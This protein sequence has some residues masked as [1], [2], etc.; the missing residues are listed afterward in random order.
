MSFKNIST[1]FYIL[2]LLSVTYG[3]TEQTPQQSSNNKIKA[4]DYKVN[5]INSNVEGYILRDANSGFVNTSLPD[6]SIL[7]GHEGLDP[8]HV[9]GAR[10]YD[11]F[12]IELG[13]T[14]AGPNP[15]ITSLA[16]PTDPAMPAANAEDSW[17]CSH[18]HGFDYEGGVYEFNNGAT[19]NLLE[20]KDVRGRDEEFVIHMLMN[21]FD[22]WDGAGVV[23]V[24]NYTGLLTP[25]AMVDVADF[26]VN[27]IFDTH[28]YV[29]APTSG[30][31]NPDSHM[32]GMAFYNS[33][34]TGAIPPVIRVDGSNFNCVDCH[35][36]DGLL[37]PGIDLFT[38][39]WTNPF[40]W[41]H[42]VNFGSPRSLATFPDFTLDQTVH[43]GLYEVVLTD[44]LHF[45]GPEQASALLAHAEKN[46]TP[47]P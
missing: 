35:G 26:V 4:V 42:R 29:Q 46:L 41:L 15:L 40:Q 8:S 30:S 3:C 14:I 11:N 7:A 18:C 20:L 34:A 23:N 22:A 1:A 37:V 2:I 33:V 10:I 27:E 12:V 19:N 39:A 13:A 45:G 21:G 28:M 24:H 47:A 5:Q 32:D 31:T 17:R 38:L 25:Q 6:N 36:A 16:A 9:R 44:G 43:P